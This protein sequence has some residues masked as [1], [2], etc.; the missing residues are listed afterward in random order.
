M[1][2]GGG[3]GGGKGRNGGTTVSEWGKVKQSVSWN[4]WY[5]LSP[6]RTLFWSISEPRKY[7]QC[8]YSSDGVEPLFRARKRYLL[9]KGKS[10]T[11]TKH[12]THSQA[13]LFTVLLTHPLL[14]LPHKFAQSVQLEKRNRENTSD[15]RY[16]PN[17]YIQYR[18]WNRNINFNSKILQYYLTPYDD[19]FQ[20]STSRT[21]ENKLANVLRNLLSWRCAVK[22]MTLSAH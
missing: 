17:C 15:R 13:L 12:W 7:R 1:S 4:C 8:T 10:F 22:V 21:V 14:Q 6:P 2:E 19:F 3:E 5:L 11:V 20:S 16:D 18:N 9:C